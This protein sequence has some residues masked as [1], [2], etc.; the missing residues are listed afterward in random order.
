MSLPVT[1]IVTGTVSNERPTLQF[2]Q[3]TGGSCTVA[4]KDR[5][6]DAYDL[7]A[8]HVVRFVMREWETSESNYVVKTCT[9]DATNNTATVTLTAADLPYSGIWLGQFNISLNDVVQARVACYVEIEPDLTSGDKP[10]VSITIPELRML[11]RDRA[12]LDNS[13]LDAVEF[14]NT[15]IMAALRRPVEYFNETPPILPQSY[16]AATFPYRYF[17]V[18]GAI[19][20]LLRIAALNLHRNRTPMNAGGLQMDSRSRADLYTKLSEEYLNRYREWVSK[21]KVSLNLS[22]F[23]GRVVNS[24]Y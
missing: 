8:S 2:Q 23:Y 19:G 3:N 21:V 17:W 20:E 15:E 4:L 10:G 22:Q 16:T 11:L 7:T 9:V 13:F 24:A 6:G 5:N 1:V 12:A 18:E 14:S